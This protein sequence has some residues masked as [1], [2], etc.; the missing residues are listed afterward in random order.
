MGIKFKN[1]NRIFI[2]RG[3]LF[4]LGNLQKLFWLTLSF[5]IAV[6]YNACSRLEPNENI[7]VFASGGCR[8]QL[9]T[10]FKATYYPIFQQHC[11]SCHS[12]FTDQGPGDFADEDLNIGIT[13]M[14]VD[15]YG[16]PDKLS[17]INKNAVDPGHPAPTS[18]PE[19]EEDIYYAN[20]S[21]SQALISYDTCI[22]S[23]PP[24]KPKTKD[25]VMS[26][27]LDPV[28]TLAY[29]P[30]SLT[31]TLAGDL[32]V[33]NDLPGVT[34]SF[35]YT[36]EGEEL[37]L[38]QCTVEKISPDG[39]CYSPDTAYKIR[40]LKV[41]TGSTPIDVSNIN[42]FF[43]GAFSGTQSTFRAIDIEVPAN[44]ID[45]QISSGTQPAILQPAEGF[46]PGIDALSF[47][48]SVLQEAEVE[49]DNP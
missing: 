4:N 13:A 5:G 22:G 15:E 28:G 7:K 38:D 10:N 21:W 48:F 45:F 23:P 33:G 42:L 39:K 34:F 44:S 12:S 18:G 27:P 49:P 8:G 36:F 9:E 43:N 14:Y 19:L 37:T 47:E 46:N 16:Y 31:M 17:L 32:E 11:K 6:T 30:V 20:Q 35:E 25:F 2:L 26:H 1:L 24:V 3:T 40:N 41:S 29:T